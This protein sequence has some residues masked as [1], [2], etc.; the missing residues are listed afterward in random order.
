MYFLYIRTKDNIKEVMPQILNIFGDS[1][2]IVKFYS[3][4]EN[5]MVIYYNYFNT[6]IN[7]VTNI[8]ISD[9]YIDIKVYNSISYKKEESIS[10]FVKI[11]NS[12]FNEYYFKENYID[13]KVILKNDYI[14]INEDIKKLVFNNYY[15][16]NMMYETIK[17]FL[18]NNQ[19][20]SEAAKILYL[21]R[22]TLTQR[23]DKFILE[24]N[25]NIKEFIDGFLI[26]KLLK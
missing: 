11:I 14:K 22:N 23:L 7:D 1:L 18:E 16:N 17:I 9:L 3:L 20:I 4:N 6:D 10:K 25:F 13:N 12:I 19:N 15:N 26:Y 5:T 21:H 8:L 24:T 2:N